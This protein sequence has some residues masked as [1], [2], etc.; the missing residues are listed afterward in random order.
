MRVATTPIV[1]FK[2]TSHERSLADRHTIIRLTQ[3]GWRAT[4]IAAHLGMHERTVR[5][6]RERFRAQGDDGLAYRSR[7]PHTPAPHTLPPHVVEAI[8][9]IRDAHPGWTTW[10]VD[11]TK[12]GGTRG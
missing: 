1:P 7:H 10:E 4:E 3:A 8:R 12:K 11:L 6:W 2:P 5:R 9:A